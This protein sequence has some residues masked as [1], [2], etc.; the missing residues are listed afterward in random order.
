MGTPI[1]Q[2]MAPKTDDSQT[3]TEIDQSL[4]ELQGRFQALLE[5][6][7]KCGGSFLLY[8]EEFMAI[9]EQMTALQTRRRPAAG[10]PASGFWR[11]PGGSQEAKSLLAGT[12]AEITEWDESL[13]RQ[14][15]GNGEGPLGPRDPGLSEGGSRRFSR[16]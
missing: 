16:K 3:L 6:V 9:N 15:G 4:E 10:G 12:P 11:S 2:E 13:V 1:R 7:Q 14:N 5:E 8:Q